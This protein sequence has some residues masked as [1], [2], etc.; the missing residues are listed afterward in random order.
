MDRIRETPVQ[1][2]PK[3]QPEKQ[4]GIDTSHSE[5]FESLTICAVKWVRGQARTKCA[6][7]V[8]QICRNKMF[9]DSKQLGGVYSPLTVFIR[10][11]YNLPLGPSVSMTV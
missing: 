8:S 4:T 3:L 1:Q 7:C 11:I 5:R 6:A 2:H 10:I 9:G